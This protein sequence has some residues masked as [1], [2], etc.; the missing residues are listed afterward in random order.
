MGASVGRGSLQHIRPTRSTEFVHILQIITRGRQSPTSIPREW[1]EG[2][3]KRKTK[4]VSTGTAEIEGPYWNP[5][6]LLLQL[7]DEKE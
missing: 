7:Q 1:L 4:R 6:E 5:D 2:E 3:R